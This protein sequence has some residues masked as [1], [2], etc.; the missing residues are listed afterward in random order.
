MREFKALNELTFALGPFLSNS[1]GITPVTDLALTGADEKA[2]IKFGAT[3][4]VSISANSWTAITSADGHYLI[5]LTN[6][7]CDTVGPLRI[8]IQDDSKCL[9]FFEDIL[10]V[11][12]DYYNGKYGAVPFA[13][14]IQVSSVDA[15]LL[16]FPNSQTLNAH[17]ITLP[18]SEALNGH[19]LTLP[20]S[21]QLTARIA[22]LPNSETLNTLILTRPSSEAVMT[23]IGTLPTSAHIADLSTKV[24]SFEATAATPTSVAS[25]VFNYVIEGTRPFVDSIRIGDAVLFGVSSG[26]NTSTIA[27]FNTAVSSARV[28]ATVNSDGNR[29]AV[30]LVGGA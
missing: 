8:S 5:M 24:S 13:T 20:T 11:T 29:S 28:I 26:G 2:I 22:T 6:S 4:P 15:R 10:L 12:S 25:A 16:T 7:Q 1:N 27:F 19:I 3:A 21:A 17:V 23:M 14:G 30:T 9:P 18:T